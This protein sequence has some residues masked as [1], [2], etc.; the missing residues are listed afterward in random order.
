MDYNL[1]HGQAFVQIPTSGI[2]LREF[3]LNRSKKVYKDNLTMKY[4]ILEWE[5]IEVDS[6][7][8]YAKVLRGIIYLTNIMTGETFILTEESKHILNELLDQ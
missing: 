7:Y 5:F 6:N 3:P 1:L 8:M 2:N 4:A